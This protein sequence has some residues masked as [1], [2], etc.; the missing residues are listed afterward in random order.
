[1]VMGNKCYECGVCCKLFMINLTEAEYKS[2]SYK[3][4]FDAFEPM[5]DF[6]EA[7]MCGAN[8]IEQKEDGSCIYVNNGN[9]SIH[10]KRPQACRAFFC[11][12]KNKDFAG[13]IEKIEEFK[14]LDNSCCEPILSPI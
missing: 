6:V 1:M 12:S 2:G 5:D 9:C 13:M 10:D 8:I 14:R 3:T 7:E 11:E 4:Q